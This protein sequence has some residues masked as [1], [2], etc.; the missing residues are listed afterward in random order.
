MRADEWG[1]V[2]EIICASIRTWYAAAGKPGRF[3]NGPTS[4]LLFPQVY[5][6]LDPGCCVVAEDKETGRLAGSCFYHP[7]ETHIS[8]GI[9]NAHPDYFNQGIAKKLL[10]HICEIADEQKKPIRLVS[11]A[12]NLDSFS[13]YTRA[14]FTP[15]AVFHDMSIKVPE[16]GLPV[17]CEGLARVRPARAEDAKAMSELEYELAGIRRENDYRHFIENAMG[18]WHTLVIESAAGKIDGFLVSIFH[19]ASN[20]IGP[21]V[22]RSEADAAALIL[23]QLNHHAGR[24]PVCVVPALCGGLVQQLYKWGLRN[25]EIHFFQCRGEAQ[26]LKGVVMP[27]FMPETG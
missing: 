5:E 19:P 12:M 4:C 21:G 2:A 9:M 15:R 27:T 11:S 25:A 6:A 14:G 26:P 18:I 23:A 22:M 16:G 3:P 20:M 1:A 24:S 17:S 7:R 8:L 10:Q 13:L